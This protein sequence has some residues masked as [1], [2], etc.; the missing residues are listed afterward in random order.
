MNYYFTTT[1]KDDFDTAIQK[2][3]EELKKE[4]FGILTEIDVKETFK[5]KL[6]VDFR[7]YRIL[8]ACN[9]QMAHQAISAESK[10][11]T[12]LP[13][14]V[15]VQETEDGKVE[16][17]AVDPVASMQAVKNDTLG[18]VATQVRDKLKKVIEQ[19]N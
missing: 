4:G 13:C 9:P 8:G 14:N 6:D 7:K 3:T 5:K 10:I 11:G 16:V 12:M 17:S 15:I 19:L 2:V 1:L 18:G